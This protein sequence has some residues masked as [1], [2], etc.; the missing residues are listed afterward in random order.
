MKLIEGKVQ[1]DAFDVRFTTLTFEKAIC[2]CI[3]VRLASSYRKVAF[4][5]ISV[6][7]VYEFLSIKK[8]QISVIRY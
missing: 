2:K 1:D 8:G 7:L 5:G 3:S 6:R 4:D